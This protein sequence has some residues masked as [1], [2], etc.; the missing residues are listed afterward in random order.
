MNDSTKTVSQN[1]FPPELDAMLGKIPDAVIADLWKAL[2]LNGKVF[3]MLDPGELEV[4]DFVRKHGRKYGVV[5]TVM[6]EADPAELAKAGSLQ[7]KDEIMRRVNSTVS[8][9]LS[10]VSAQA[11]P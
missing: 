4:F 10:Q 9:V 8:V 1:A 7:Q 3:A 11:Q 2:R 6:S 5:A